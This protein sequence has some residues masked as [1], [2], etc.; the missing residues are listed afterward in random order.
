M[1][2]VT[3]TRNYDFSPA[4]LGGRVT[5]AYKKGT[6][7]LVNRECADGALAAGA[8]VKVKK[9]RDDHARG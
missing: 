3:F 2:W 7:L 5:V 1:P 6:T 8:A 4:K 9:E